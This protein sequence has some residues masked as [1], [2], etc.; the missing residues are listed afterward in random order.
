[1]DKVVH[2]LEKCIAEGEFT[3]KESVLSFQWTRL[4]T[5]LRNALQ[6]VNKCGTE[7]QAQKMH[8]DYWR[9]I[10]YIHTDQ[11]PKAAVIP[12]M[13]RLSQGRVGK[14]HPE[15]LFTRRRAK[16]VELDPDTHADH[17]EI[18]AMT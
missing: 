5:S 17:F 8:R 10:L 13:L 11:I 6:K 12:Y 1:M 16:E 14:E 2:E 15:T 3:L 4:Y 9:E 18:E 7:E